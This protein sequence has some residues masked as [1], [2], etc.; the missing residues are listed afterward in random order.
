MGTKPVK[1]DSD[2]FS[3]FTIGQGHCIGN[4]VFLSGQASINDAGEV[5]GS[6]DIN[7]QI[8]QAMA[9]IKRAQVSDGSSIERI[10]K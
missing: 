4:L 9:N 5:V 10:F 2:V 1:V 7:V 3:A 6:D 8:E